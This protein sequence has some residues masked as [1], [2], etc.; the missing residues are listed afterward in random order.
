MQG[1]S[2]RD[3]NLNGKTYD[4]KHLHPFSFKA[5]IKGATVNISVAFS[6]HC[7][8]DKKG[9]GKMLMSGRY[10]CESRYQRSLDLRKILVDHVVNGHIVPHFDRNS[11]EVYYYAA[12]YDYVVFFDLR[13]DA[14]N[15]GGL[16]MFVT[17]AYELDQWGKE[18]VPKGSRVRF[19]HIGQLRLNGQTFLLGKKQKGR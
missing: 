2:W 6:N 7:F 17:S 9:E 18:T 8:T 10:F 5:D 16:T 3:V 15:L 14:N 1:K 19:D 11:N 12:V 13:P 4:L